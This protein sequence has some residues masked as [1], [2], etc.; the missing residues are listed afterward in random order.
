M[1]LTHIIARIA[2]LGN[3]RVAG[4]RKETTLGT[5]TDAILDR[6]PAHLLSAKLHEKML[7]PEKFTY[8]CNGQ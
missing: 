4:Q 1:H 3:V 2:V 8:Q 7:G 5:A 6:A